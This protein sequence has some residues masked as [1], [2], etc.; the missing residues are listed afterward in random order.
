MNTTVEKQEIALIPPVT[1]LELFQGGQ[2]R[3]ILDKIKDE[4]LSVVTDPTT[5]KGRKEIASLA[6]KVARTKV[7]LD[8][9]GKSLTDE[10]RKFIDSINAER[11]V[12]V[13]ELDELKERVRRP[14]TEFEEREKARIAK[15]QNAI[16]EI[17]IIID[18]AASKRD[19]LAVE[20]AIFTLE[21]IDLSGFEEF[22][23]QAETEKAAGLHRLGKLS[24]E[25]RAERIERERIAKEKA[26]AEA[27][28]RAEREAR[29]AAEAAERAR[30]EAERRAA[31]EARKAE[32]AREA[33]RKAEADR[34]A[35]IEAEKA[36]AERRAKEAAERAERERIEAEERHRRELAEAE[37]K[38]KR[39]AEER[40]HA[41]IAAQEAERKAEEK[42]TANKRRQ[43]DCRS[44]AASCFLA[45][46]LSPEV[47]NQVVTLIA[48]GKIEHVT[49]NY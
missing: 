2:V 14:L 39:E 17:R 33:E 29:I 7:A 16:H 30:I 8:E 27:R 21:G 41:R 6:H 46:G 22:R 40:E 26:E 5:E 28:E 34:L 25:L 1:A 11:R 10:Q 42:R 13:A 20:E 35:A 12:I 45:H 47:A 48:E 9:M 23:G 37:A 43:A 31:E 18:E 38:A 3:T 32:E 44:R 36:A 49:I 19:S 24:E 4:I 15:H